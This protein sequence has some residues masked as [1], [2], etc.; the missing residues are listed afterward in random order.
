[1]CWF[2]QQ[3]YLGLIAGTRQ[4]INLMRTNQQIGTKELDGS[5][6]LKY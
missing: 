1:M 5:I 6:I 3:S 4:R 2:W